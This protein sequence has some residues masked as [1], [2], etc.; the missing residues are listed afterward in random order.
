MEVVILK[1]TASNIDNISIQPNVSV[2][3]ESYVLI[4][5]TRPLIYRPKANIQTDYFHD[6]NRIEVRYFIF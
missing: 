2:S 3:A 6:L 4:K 5:Y 1:V